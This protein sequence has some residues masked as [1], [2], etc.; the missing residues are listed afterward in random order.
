[1]AR[2]H[3]TAM[4]EAGAVL[5]DDVEIGPF[6]VVGPEVELKAGVV[7]RSHVVITGRTT[8][9][10]DCKVYSF[11][12]LGEPGQIYKNAAAEP[13]RLEIGPRC[14][15][16]EYVTVNCGSP[17]GDLVTRVGDDCMMMVGSHVAHDCR[18]G[19][20]VIFANNAT[21]GGHVTVGDNVFLGG[22]C[23]V[24]QFVEIG[25]QAIIGGMT[26]VEGH[27]IPFGRVTGDRATLDGLNII[28]LE[29]RGFD[30]AAIRRLD[31]AFKQ[32]FH[33]DGTFAER[34]ASVSEEYADEPNVQRIA[35]FIKGVDKRRPLTQA[36]R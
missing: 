11:A 12:S 9:G 14:E 34:L 10:E 20:N 19:K 22:L 5:A 17:R 2:I 6:C 35:A 1:M 16:R 32:L 15:L 7:L 25:E 26:G 29:R 33:G 18:I 36:A 28:G 24:H 4:V 13:G 27:V 21:L 3:P 23:A 8:L 30:R 31:V